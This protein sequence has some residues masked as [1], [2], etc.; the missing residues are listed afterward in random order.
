MKETPEA[1][2]FESEEDALQ[3]LCDTLGKKVK[4]AI[5]GEGLE[6]VVDRTRSAQNQAEADKGV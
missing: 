5:I 3:Y 2:I 4:I 1:L 6:H